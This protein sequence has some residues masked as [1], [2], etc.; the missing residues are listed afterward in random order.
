[1][2]G[3]EKAGRAENEES[4]REEKGEGTSGGVRGRPSQARLLPRSW[5]CLHLW[6]DPLKAHSTVGAVI[7]FRPRGHPR[8][9]DL[10][11]LVVPQ[12]PPFIHLLAGHSSF[13]GKLCHPLGSRDGQSWCGQGSRGGRN[14]GKRRTALARGSQRWYVD[15]PG[16]PVQDH[17]WV[18]GLGPSLRPTQL[19]SGSRDS[20]TQLLQVKLWA[21]PVEWT[22]WAGPILW[23]HLLIPFL[24]G[25][26]GVCTPPQP[27]PSPASSQ[28]QRGRENPR[29]S[30]TPGS[31]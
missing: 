13:S 20:C 17:E 7:L 27:C 6:G 18:K 25:R 30:I 8:A 21:L 23:F 3:M 10:S 14:R 2:L 15:S 22:L 29:P 16:W 31:P 19:T 12:K 9:L 4:G 26:R 11:P 1:M 28:A 5:A 24:E